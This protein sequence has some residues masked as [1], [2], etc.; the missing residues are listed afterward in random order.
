MKKILIWSSLLVGVPLLLFAGSLVFILTLDPNDYRDEIEKLAAEQGVQ[1]NIEGELGWKLFPEL[2]LVVNDTGLQATMDGAEIDARIQRLDLTL[3]IRPLLHK[4]LQFRGLNIYGA[5]L[6]LQSDPVLADQESEADVQVPRANNSAVPAIYFEHLNIESSRIS[7]FSGQEETLLV[8]NIQLNTQQLNLRG[9]S[10]YLQMSFN[11]SGPG[12]QFAQPVVLQTQLALTAEEINMRLASLSVVPLVSGVAVPISASGEIAFTPS[13]QSIEASN[14]QIQSGD[15]L[16]EGFVQGH[17][18]PLALQG[19]VQTNEWNFRQQIQNMGIQL[20]L[21]DEQALSVGQLA[22]DLA[23]DEEQLRLDNLYLSLDSSNLEGQLVLTLSTIPEFSFVG[24]LDSIDL[25]RYL[26]G[27]EET[28]VTAEQPTQTE[29][30]YAASIALEIGQLQSFGLTLSAID[31]LIS[32]NNRQVIVEKFNA[33]LAGGNISLN[34]ST[35]ESPGGTGHSFNLVAEDILL[36]QLLT[37]LTGQ[38][39]VRGRI[40]AQFAA[41]SVGNSGEEIVKNAIGNGAI[42]AADLSL[43]GVDVEGMVCDISDRLQR[44]SLTSNYGTMADNTA[45][46]DMSANIMLGNGLAQITG[47][48]AAIGNIKASGVGRFNL[49]SMQYRADLQARISAEKTS[50]NGCTVNQY[51]RNRTLPLVCTGGLA[52]ANSA[53]I[54]PS[55]SIDQDFVSDVIRQA[56]GQNLSNRL[57]I[58]ST[59]SDAEKPAGQQLLEGLL[60]QFLK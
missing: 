18:Q 9:D 54:K 57:Q 1:L 55:C 40:S 28:S 20:H 36:G 45:L 49:V 44:M 33:D 19:S 53:A 21:A 4:Q 43:L 30:D 23:L 50:E 29:M 32:A 31:S 46:Q 10:F 26:P 8:E 58:D 34:A 16:L 6:Q 22:F 60:N 56:I 38:A 52:T 12:L 24:S 51:L 7:L 11:L 48:E 41:N 2:V 15:M 14:W 37:D 42:N 17:L 3:Q 59:E 27:V 35:M 39:N 5:D 47:L 13:E 25:D